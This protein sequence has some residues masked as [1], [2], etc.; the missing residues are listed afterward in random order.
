MSLSPVE[1][2]RDDI[3]FLK[4]ANV[5]QGFDNLLGANYPSPSLHD[6]TFSTKVRG[7][8]SPPTRP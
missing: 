1:K 8:E 5:I 7:A 4:I 2:C 3:L 6:S